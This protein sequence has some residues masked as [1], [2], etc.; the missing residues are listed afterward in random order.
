VAGILVAAALLAC[1]PSAEAQ[2]YVR[3][4]CRPL[5]SVVGL[6]PSPLTARWYRRFWTGD[7]EKLHGCISGAPN[8]N[9]IVG[10]LAARSANSQRA[11]V[12][13]R[14]CRLGP[15]IGVE[16]TR[17]KGVRRIDTSDLRG[18]KKTL[19]SASNVLQGIEQVEAE[20]LAK[21]GPPRK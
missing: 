3:S 7:C 2:S 17:P 12:L 10:E 21:I 4:E 8:W 5:V 14:A 16:W 13:T 6:D 19:E 9:E 15:L 1:A 18:F 20:T 11:M